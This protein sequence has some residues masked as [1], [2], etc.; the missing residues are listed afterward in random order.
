MYIV[1]LPIVIAYVA[2]IEN[3][4]YSHKLMVHR[5][6]QYLQIMAIIIIT[7]DLNTNEVVA[8]QSD[9]YTQRLHCI[10]ACQLNMLMYVY[11]YSL[12]CF[13]FLLYLHS[14]G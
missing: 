1:D 14:S 3:L 4:Y 13:F 9:H 7:S 12:H 5:Q 8:L 10:H 6:S 11:Q 2:V